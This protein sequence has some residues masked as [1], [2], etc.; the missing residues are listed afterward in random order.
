MS[1][2]RYEDDIY[3]LAGAGYSSACEVYMSKTAHWRRLP[4]CINARSAATPASHNKKIYLL[5]GCGTTTCEYLDTQ[6]ETFHLLPLRLLDEY[7]TVA[8]CTDT[9]LIAVQELGYYTCNIDAP[10]KSWERI[11]FPFDFGIAFWSDCPVFCRD[12]AYYIHQN[13][14]SRIIALKLAEKSYV[15]F[16]THV[17]ALNS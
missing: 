6:T 3:A 12:G 15:E 9:E 5:G 1:V 2:I 4:N 13:Y 16:P 7:C 17:P 8:L 14:C 11:N 10:P